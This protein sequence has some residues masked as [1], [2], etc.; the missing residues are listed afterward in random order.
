MSN[1]FDLYDNYGRKIGEGEVTTTSGGD[2]VSLLL[3]GLVFIV[4]V[5]AAPLWT[6]YQIGRRTWSRHGC[7]V[8]LAAGAVFFI[9]VF[10]A[11]LRL[12]FS[13]VALG[14]N[15]TTGIPT[16]KTIPPLD[17]VIAELLTLVLIFVISKR[18][19]FK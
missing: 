7:L 9:W 10:S 18:N 16:D 3:L 17:L 14:P 13:L 4:A 15:A 1:K 2:I 6:S 11:I 8:R 12:A 5:V 19:Q